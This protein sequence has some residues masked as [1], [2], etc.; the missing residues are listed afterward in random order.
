M[1]HIVFIHFLYLSQN[2]P[3][4]HHFDFLCT[5]GCLSQ[6]VLITQWPHYISSPPRGSVQMYCYQ[7]DT[8][9]EYLYWYKQLRGKSFQLIV[10]IIAGSPTLEKEFE[11]G[12][13][14]ARSETKQWSLT[15]TSVKQK[16][17]AVY[18]CAASPHSA[19]TALRSVT[20][21]H[22]RDDV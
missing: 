5:L 14:A 4:H 1:A 9:Y 10:S 11:S 16:D 17:E 18:L 21:T 8:D 3:R 2:D 12:F 22:S 6:S 20:K 19:V 15:I 7:N 13:K